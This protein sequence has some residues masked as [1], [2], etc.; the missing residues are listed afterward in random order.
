MCPSRTCTPRTPSW[1]VLRRPYTVHPPRVLMKAA[2][3]ETEPHC[4]TVFTADDE[5]KNWH[6]ARKRRVNT[7]W[8]VTCDSV[9]NRETLRTEVLVEPIT[10][11]SPFWKDCLNSSSLSGDTTKSCQALWEKVW[12]SCASTMSW[13]SFLFNRLDLLNRTDPDESVR[14]DEDML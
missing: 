14:N 4:F 11:N 13:R 2:G 9:A 7:T 8:I 3:L 10:K 12:G 6:H 5:P 1:S